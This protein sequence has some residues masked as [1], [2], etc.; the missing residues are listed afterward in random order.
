MKTIR[1]RDFQ[2]CGVTC[3]EYIIN[4]YHGYVPI[5]KLREDTFTDREGT[6]AYHIVETFKKYQFDSYGK[7]IGYHD[8]RKDFLPAIVHIVLPNGL[9]HFVVLVRVSKSE[10]VLM[11]PMIGKRTLS[12][13]DFECLWDGVILFAIPKSKIPKI[14]KEKNIFHVL[15]FFASKEK[16]ILF[17]IVFCSIISSILTI[18][19]G[20]YF[21]IGIEIM[22]AFDQNTFWIITLVF[23]LILFFRMIFEALQSYLTIFLNRN[24]EVNYMYAFLKHLLYLPIQKF[25]SYHEGDIMTRVKEAEEIKNLFQNVCITFF[26]GIILVVISFPVLAMLNLELSLLTLA[27]M[28][29][30]FGVSFLLSKDFYHFILERMNEERRWNENLLET[31]KIFLSMKHL[32]QTTYCL[33]NLEKDF[34]MYEK[35]STY[36]GQKVTFYQFMRENFLEILFFGLLTF[37]MWLV[38]KGEIELLNLVTFQSLYTYFVTPL[39]ELA[40]IGPKFFYMKGI[41]LKLSEMVHM[42]EERVEERL[43]YLAAPSIKIEKL[44][45]SYNQTINSLEGLNLKIKAKEHVFLQ[46]PSGCGKSTLCKILHLDI[47]NYTGKILFSDKNLKDYDISDIRSSVVYL[48]QQESL[49]KGT[50]KE[51]ILFGSKDEK[52]FEKICTICKLE[53]FVCNRPL[54]YETFIHEEN[55]SGGEKQRIL[56]A[57]AL[58][59]PA[60]LYLFDECLSEVNEKLEVEIIKNIRKYLKD[61]TMIYISHKNHQE[62]FERSIEM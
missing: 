22:N 56:L 40:D 9:N 44:T 38:G 41:L 19:G 36:Y 42:E 48:S 31:I 20:V 12:K 43:S 24:I 54:R 7:K 30:Y 58:L 2:D 61:K 60:S 45:Y 53:D 33:N 21:K 34:C 13:K 28:M 26:R 17:F 4:H 5:E 1:Q 25:L 59:K 55:V 46:G 8:L 23:L 29:F 49:F 32:N 6:S 39:K 10:V 51:N 50:M 18:I 35:H 52:G 15:L 62:L 3:M 16:R 57:R 14:P 47:T 11:D 27:G 37:G